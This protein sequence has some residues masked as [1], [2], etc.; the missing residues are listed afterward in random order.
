MKSFNLL[1]PQS[2][3]EATS[4]L[5]EEKTV[6]LAGGTDLL[7]VLKDKILPEYPLNVVD[8]KTIDGLNE[9]RQDDKG[10]SI[11]AMA[12]LSEIVESDI[13]KENAPALVD[14]AKSVAHLNIRN[15]GTLGGNLCQDSRCWYYRYPHQIGGR[16][17]CAR[18]TGDVCYALM[19]ENR[20]HSI[21]GGAKVHTS[22]CNQSCPTGTDIPGYLER[23]RAGDIDGA[24][25]IIMKVNPMPAITSRVCAHFCMEGCKRQSY[26]ESVNIGAIERY[27]GDYILEHADLFMKAPEFENGK[28]VAIVGAGPAGL[29]AA[30][31][32]RDAGYKVT[33][34]ERM[35]KAGGCL[36]YA[37]PP[38]RL[39]KD[40]VDKFIQALENMGVVFNLKTHVGEE[41]LPLEEIHKNYDSVML[42]TGA[43]KR[44]L[45]GISGEE[46]TRFGLDF[47]V[48]VNHFILDRP[49]AKVIVVGGGNVAVDVAV[50][51]KR[52]GSK[53]V[54]LVALEPRD[55][56]PAGTEEIERLV[57]EGIEIING[58]G[59]KEIIKDEK[60]VSGMVFKACPKVFDETGRFAPVYDE[61]RLM[62]LD[63]DVV[64]MAIGQVA[65]LDFLE[66]SFEI[67][68][69]RGRIKALEGN[70][71]SVEGIYAGGDVTTGPATVVEA[72]AAGKNT[73]VHM[74]HYLMGENK[75]LELEDYDPKDKNRLL[76]FTADTYERV[77]A[78]EAPESDELNVLDEDV[79]ELAKDAI[80]AEASRCVNCG[81]LA[82]NPSD[83]ANMLIAMGAKLKTNQRTVSA[84][85]F[86]TR[87]TKITDQLRPAEIVEE[88]LIPKLPENTVAS[89]DKFRLR[90]TID[91]AIVALASVFTM[92]EGKIKNADLVLGAVAPIPIRCSE[93]EAFLM[94]KEPTE[95]VAREAA[96]IALKDALQLPHNEFKIV[97]AKT[98]IRRAVEALA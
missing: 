37:I 68:T 97:N 45:I 39:P 27:V 22:A 48:D 72:V 8:L 46:M 70:Q 36:T 7:G 19:G 55:R 67:E 43:W 31:Y 61:S 5:A 54:K 35:A 44:P 80:V 52:L 34:F 86:F 30:Y 11:G 49:G 84:E 73:A 24:A 79:L 94:G 60:G 74:N 41:G 64:L 6:A 51:A 78:I 23:V 32:L 95:E 4:L 69:E 25:R 58:W 81:C 89:Y 98:L 82:V 2:L 29:T 15:V 28:S 63:G 77:E 20:Y 14:A 3:E 71:T 93:A 38:Y 16:V 62:T 96:E 12:T 90:E 40:I 53:D 66:G 1:K 18:K 65:D 42:D 9:I 10:I 47:L 57:N 88:I 87:R 26:D 59:P 13:I 33:F 76:S 56:M 85:V 17:D 75:N 50:T 92:E 83:M 21:F 91:F